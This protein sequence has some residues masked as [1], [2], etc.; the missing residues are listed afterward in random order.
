MILF[1]GF[2]LSSLLLGIKLENAS[3][4]KTDKQ[5]D[6]RLKLERKHFKFGHIFV[7]NSTTIQIF[8]NDIQ[9]ILSNSTYLKSFYNNENLDLFNIKTISFFGNRIDC[10]PTDFLVFN[11]GRAKNNK[12]S[13]EFYEQVILKYNE[14]RYN[15]NYP[16]VYSAQNPNC[17][18]NLISYYK[19][20]FKDYHDF[21]IGRLRFGQYKAVE[22]NNR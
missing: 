22:D 6:D 1:I 12:I 5:I 21:H 9:K 14:S 10:K 13:S 18:K 15:M 7:A 3:I 4:E 8:H 11:A 16:S 19:E 17:L 2:G 20:N